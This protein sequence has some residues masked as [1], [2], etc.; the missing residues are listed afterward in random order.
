LLHL[1]E[2]QA[3]QILSH[4][5]EIHIPKAVEIEMKLLDSKWRTPSWIT[6][7]PS[8][9]DGRHKLRLGSKQGC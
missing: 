6:V 9:H 8:K 3:L 7:D 2:T 5:G 1:S 4:A